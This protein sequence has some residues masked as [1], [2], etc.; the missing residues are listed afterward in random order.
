LRKGWQLAQAYGV[1]VN[2]GKSRE[3]TF[4]AWDRI[5]VIAED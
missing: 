5:I 2:P 3:V 1:V 4:A